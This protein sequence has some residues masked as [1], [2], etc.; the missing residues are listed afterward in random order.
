[1]IANLKYANTPPRKKVGDCDFTC[2]NC[3]REHHRTLWEEQD[4]PEEGMNLI[5]ADAKCRC[6]A[7]LLVADDMEHFNV[8]WLNKQK[9]K[10]KPS[11][12][13]FLC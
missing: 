1:M 4:D 11:P 7:L 6:G 2:P 9:M 5:H 3:G 8:Y 13:P 10:A 12:T